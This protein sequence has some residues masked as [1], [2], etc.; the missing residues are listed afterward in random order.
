MFKFSLVIVMVGFFFS[1]AAEAAVCPKPANVVCE[2]HRKCETAAGF[3]CKCDGS[4][5][6]PMVRFTGAKWN[7][8][9]FNGWYPKNHVNCGYS[10]AGGG[11]VAV[12][13]RQVVQTSLKKANFKGSWK[14]HGNDDPD[15]CGFGSVPCA[16]CLTS[17]VNS[18]PLP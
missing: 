17:N 16:K 3:T 10:D 11:S 18:C 15:P 9:A 14:F 5:K 4:K 8:Y 13:T 2:K 6:G 12:V 7:V 1:F